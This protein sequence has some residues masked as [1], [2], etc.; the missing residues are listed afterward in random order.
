MVSQLPRWCINCS[1][2][3]GWAFCVLI[4]VDFL[5]SIGYQTAFSVHCFKLIVG[6]Q[7]VENSQEFP[8]FL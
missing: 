8:C 7:C 2:H 1:Y 6:T 4:E 3:K 5:S